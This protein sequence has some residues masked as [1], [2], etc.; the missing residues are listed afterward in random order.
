MKALAPCF[1]FELRQTHIKTSAPSPTIS[2][3]DIPSVIRSPNESAIPCVLLRI[4][5]CPAMLPASVFSILKFARASSPIIDIKLARYR[6]SFEEK[7]TGRTEEAARVEVRRQEVAVPGHGALR[8]QA[9]HVRGRH[10]VLQVFPEVTGKPDNMTVKE[11]RTSSALAKDKI[12]SYAR[13]ARR[14]VNPVLP[15]EL[16]PHAPELHPGMN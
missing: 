4:R 10:D 2:K 15:L 6:V 3:F 12:G 5:T 11:E 9:R 13:Y 8:G 14:N 1:P 7:T 16:R